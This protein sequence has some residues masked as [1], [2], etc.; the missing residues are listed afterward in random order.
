[1]SDTRYAVYRTNTCSGRQLI[2]YARGSKDDILVFYSGNHVITLEEVI[3]EYIP[4][5][6][7]AAYRAK[8]AEIKALEAK[9]KVLYD[10]IDRNDVLGE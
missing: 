3:C 5:G 6:Y 8:M 1:M 2:A 10:Q 4:V 7:A 9:V